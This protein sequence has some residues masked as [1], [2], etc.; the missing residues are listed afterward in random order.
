[1]K[2]FPICVI[3]SMNGGFKMA[4]YNIGDKVICIKYSI[5]TQI[6]SDANGIREENF[7]DTSVFN[8]VATIKDTYK[9][10]M[11]NFFKVEYEDKGEYIIEFED[12]KTLSWV[13]DEELIPLLTKHS[14]L[15]AVFAK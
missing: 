11:E 10:Y 9:N 2:S 8:V 12:G 13:T 5:G 6:V 14:M 15:N 4:K 1:M 7:V 3:V